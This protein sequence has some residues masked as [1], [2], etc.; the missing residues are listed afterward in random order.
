[1]YKDRQV[2]DR[3][4]EQKKNNK[5]TLLIGARQVGK[6]TLLE[7]LYN[8]L[9]KKS[10]KLFLDLDVYSNYER[11]STYENCLNTLKINGYEQGS[12]QPFFL[13][14]DEFQR[15]SDISMVLKDLADHHP[16]IKVFAS[17]A[18]SLAINKRAQERLA[19][20]KRT[21]R[22]YPLSFREYLGFI[23]RSDLL[24]KD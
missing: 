14:L 16:D 4:E 17:G 20:R 18:S 7:E 10:P 8:R 21:I 6:T 3:L 1:M 24:K 2:Y 11:V 19:G 22:V 23:D 5:I 13:F 15:Y 12:N 9:P